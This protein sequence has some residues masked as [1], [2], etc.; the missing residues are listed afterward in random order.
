MAKFQKIEKNWIFDFFGVLNTTKLNFKTFLRSKIFWFRPSNLKKTS[1]ISL[2]CLPWP[3][4]SKLE[5]ELW[6]PENLGLWQLKFWISKKWKNGFLRNFNFC[7]V[8]CF[9]KMEE[10]FENFFCPS[11]VYGQRCFEPKNHKDWPYRF[12]DIATIPSKTWFFTNF[13]FLAF[14]T[15]PNDQKM[16]R[17]ARSQFFHVL[18]HQKNFC[19]NW[20]TLGP[21]V[22]GPPWIQSD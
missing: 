21:K 15:H 16:F 5:A 14:L 2:N 17:R 18:K 9:S 19:Q 13:T 8:G 10:N 7:K 6:G 11:F 3:N 12:G 20:G 22:F 4:K 1:K